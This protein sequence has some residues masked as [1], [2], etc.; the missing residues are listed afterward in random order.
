MNCIKALP[1]EDLSLVWQPV[2]RKIALWLIHWRQ[3]NP[4]IRLVLI[5]GTDCAFSER[6]NHRQLLINLIRQAE[7]GHGLAPSE[8]IWA[9]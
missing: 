4:E 8:I 1:Q 2:L 9:R 7:N 3:G 6:N 5:K